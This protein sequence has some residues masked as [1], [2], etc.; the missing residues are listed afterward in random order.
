MELAEL[1]V[2]GCAISSEKYLVKMVMLMQ[3]DDFYRPFHRDIFVAVKEMR[4]AKKKVYP[5]ALVQHLRD[6]GKLSDDESD[7]YIGNA[8][9]HSVYAPSFD[10]YMKVVQ[11]YGRLRRIREGI[12]GVAMQLTSTEDIDNAV[13]TLKDLTRPV[14][15]SG[16]VTPKNINL[17][18][19]V[20][21]VPFVFGG[22]N[23]LM[24]E[25]GLARGQIT[26]IGA[27]PGGGKTM[28]M[29][30]DFKH[31]A[32]GNERVVYATFGDQSKEQ[33]LKRLM[34]QETGYTHHSMIPNSH[35]RE[36]RVKEWQQSRGDWNVVRDAHFYEACMVRS[37]LGRRV[38]QFGDEMR[39]FR[40]KG[41]IDRIYVD[42][43]QCVE[44][45]AKS[46][47]Q[48]EELGAVSYYLRSLAEELNVAL[49]VGTQIMVDQDGN[50]KPKGAGKL[51]ED[52]ALAIYLQWH[53]GVDKQ[54]EY[55][56]SYARVDDGKPI[57][58]AR[59]M[60]NRF[61]KMGRVNLRWNDRNTRFEE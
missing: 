1:V 48:H 27:M 55:T 7:G 59:V 26:L 5:A 2:I 31:A 15:T 22:I 58:R 49:V 43:I 11:D 4:A 52:A 36:E 33:L 35:D 45:E 29:L 56:W 44:P 41:P 13:A 9:A 12:K 54:G 8:T 20:D 25:K 60:K 10:E 30:E 21:S 3:E 28:M 34:Y 32:D 39:L 37:G 46:R 47:S 24:Q 14:G 40:E 18:Q 42:Y 23:D 38:D 51:F 19:E 57:A 50:A 17:D 6:T 16:L 61:G 53:K